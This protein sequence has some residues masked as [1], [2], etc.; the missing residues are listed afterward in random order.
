M[1]TVHRAS[2]IW[3]NQIPYCWGNTC[4]ISCALKCVFLCV[5]DLVCARALN[6]LCATRNLAVIFLQFPTQVGCRPP[7]SAIIR[8]IFSRRDKVSH[9]S[10]CVCVCF[11]SADRTRQ[12]GWPFVWTRR[13]RRLDNLSE[14]ATRP[15]L[16]LEAALF[17][18]RNWGRQKG[19]DGQRPS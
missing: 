5:C 14:K 8:R 12:S 4:T 19:K 6:F 11:V 13:S 17:E 2:L 16:T 1:Q 18:S 10:A 15:I 9:G 3:P 7:S